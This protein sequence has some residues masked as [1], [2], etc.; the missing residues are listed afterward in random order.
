MSLDKCCVD[1]LCSWDLAF[2]GNYNNIPWC[3]MCYG[4]NLLRA[5]LVYL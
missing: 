5:G 2:D 1:K 4:L 3:N